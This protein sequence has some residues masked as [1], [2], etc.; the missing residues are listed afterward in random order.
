LENIII[1][2]AQI[3]Y[4]NKADFEKIV[5]QVCLKRAVAFKIGLKYYPDHPN[6][7]AII[8]IFEKLLFKNAGERK[9]TKAKKIAEVLSL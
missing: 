8:R 5:K 2:N 6:P 7:K 4:K 1:E 3:A 9:Q